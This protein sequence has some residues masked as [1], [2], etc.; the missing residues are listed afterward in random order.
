MRRQRA[1]IIIVPL[2]DVDYFQINKL[3]TALAGKF[4]HTVD[5]LQGVKLPHEAFNLIKGQHFSTVI[6]Q[7]LELLRT[8]DKERILGIME[9]DIYNARNHVLPYDVDR[10]AGTGLLSMFHLKQQFYGLPDDEKEIYRRLVKTATLIVG[11][12]FGMSLCRN[13]KCVMYYS[14]E[15]FDVDQKGEKMC[16]N[17]RRYYLKVM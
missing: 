6:L 8:G 4:G 12:L 3:S 1:K 13:P 14:N 7:K 2:G 5:L 11:R 15:M 17:C 10:I 16:D 9:E